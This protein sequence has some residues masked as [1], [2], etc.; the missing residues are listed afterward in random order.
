MK[1][2]NDTHRFAARKKEWLRQYKEDQMQK[3]DTQGRHRSEW[4]Y[5]AYDGRVPIRVDDMFLGYSG[6]KK[7]KKM[8][9]DLLEALKK[10]TERQWVAAY[11]DP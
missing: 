1:I 9:S 6:M 4:C 2:E 7:I 11:K 5:A 3:L 8:N 10:G